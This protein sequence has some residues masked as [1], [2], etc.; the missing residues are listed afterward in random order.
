MEHRDTPRDIIDLIARIREAANGLIEREL[1]ARGLTGIVPAHGLVFAFLFRQQ[2]PVPIK[3]L[4]RQSGRVKSTVTG[5][6]NTLEKHGYLY[7]RECSEDARSTLIGLTEKGRA[8]RR[9]FE[10]IS[11]VLEQQVYGDMGTDDRRH[12]MEL[13]SAIDKNLKR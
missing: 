8:I 5:M 9:D 3:D 4:V 10:A 11:V 13:L 1:Q 6:V 7:K 2:G 12:V